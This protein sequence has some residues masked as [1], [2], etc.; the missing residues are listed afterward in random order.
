MTSTL[1]VDEV[2]ELIFNDHEEWVQA[3]LHMHS[4]CGL[5]L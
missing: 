5:R 4:R 3:Q 2:S 1:R